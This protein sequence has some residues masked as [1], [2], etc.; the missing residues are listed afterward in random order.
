MRLWIF[1]IFS[2]L[3]VLAG[4]GTTRWSDTQRTATEQL[5]ISDAI[6]RAVSQIDFDPVA[7]KKVYLDIM[8][9]KANVD[10]AYLVST[11]RQQLLAVGCL[12]REKP[13][14]ADYVVEIRAG[15]IGT[16]RRDLLFGVPATRVPGVPGAG[17][18]ASIPEIA[19][20]TKTEQRAVAKIAVFAYN[21]RT[22]RPVWQSGVIPVESKVKDVWVL[23]TGPFQSGTIYNGTKFAGENVGMPLVGSGKRHI[24]NPAAPAAAKEAFYVESGQGLAEKDK[25][26]PQDAKKDGE[27]NV[28]DAKKEEG[29]T[30]NDAKKEEG[31]TAND[32]K[33]AKPPA[34]PA[35]GA[36]EGVKQASHN[37]PMAALA[38]EIPPPPPP[39][40]AAGKIE[41][42]GP[43][44]L[45]QS[46]DW[47]VFGKGIPGLGG[48]AGK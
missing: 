2:S 20:A 7:G 15:A 18:G 32:A 11:L 19:L 8:P 5:L 24:A 26:A 42:T 13:D 12:L 30:V 1:A 23:G 45:P 14:D 36:S 29:K 22:G 44:P 47:S 6:D 17:V 3:A 16:D 27:K 33:D 34:S 41:A 37:E 25:P 43:P 46:L 40:P 9:I 48:S 39:P 38:P 21:R 35:S 10:A 28:N 31:K 4:C